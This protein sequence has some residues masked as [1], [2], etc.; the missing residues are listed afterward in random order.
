M[1]LP[2]GRG[3]RM[4]FEHSMLRTATLCLI[5]FGAIMVYSAS[6]GTTLL[7][8][9][10][11]SSYYLKRY[12]ASAIV[13]LIALALAS[14][15][16]LP[17]VRRATP[18]LLAASLGGLVIVMMPGIGVQAN[19]AHRWIYPAALPIFPAGDSWHDN[20]N[21]VDAYWGPSVHWNTYLEQY[22]MV[23]SRAK[24]DWFAAEGIYVSF[25][26]TLDDP[27][28]WSPPAR[29]FKG[30]K[31]YPEFIGTEPGAGTD[32][33]AGQWARFFMFGTSRYVAHF[34]K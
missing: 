31:W 23:M 5:A 20:D 11:D 22:V 6:S 17:A 4:T 27:S 2:F 9:G 34:I 26:D 25:A 8:E 10:G 15:A 1:R 16:S 14:R 30:G 18:L 33:V 32:K 21:V 12:V 29:I 19:G 3:D 13:G 24:D 7:S 28:G